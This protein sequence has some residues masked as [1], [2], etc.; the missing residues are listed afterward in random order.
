MKLYA[1]IMSAGK[2]HRRTAD[3][4]GPARRTECGKPLGGMSPMT[5]V[6]GSVQAARDFVS[7]DDVQMELCKVCFPEDES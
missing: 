6:S 1:P 3:R 5:T 7:R 4:R 2:A